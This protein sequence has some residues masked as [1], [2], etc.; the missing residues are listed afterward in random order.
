M[1]KFTIRSIGEMSD[2]EDDFLGVT[3]QGGIDDVRSVAKMFGKPVAIVPADL[4]DEAEKAL[5]GMLETHIAHHNNPAHV[6][7][8]S[9][10]ARIRGEK[11]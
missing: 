2:D 7:A 9:T 5:A 10:L 3:V 1:N 8:R 6:A 11:A 4:L